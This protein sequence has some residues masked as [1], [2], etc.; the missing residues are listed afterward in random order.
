MKLELQNLAWTGD[1]TGKLNLI[2]LSPLDNNV[3]TQL[4]ICYRL[5]KNV[6]PQTIIGAII[7]HWYLVGFVFRDL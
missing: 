1:K 4:N 6:K 2:K 7:L 5:F 3:Y